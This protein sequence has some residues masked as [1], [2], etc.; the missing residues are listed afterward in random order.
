[1]NKRIIKVGTRASELALTQTI[2]VVNEMKKHR[3]DFEFETVKITTQGDKFL[4]APLSQIGGKGLFVKEIENALLSGDIHMAVHSMKDIPYEI[5]EKL[6]VMA[7]LKREDPRD[8]F[9]SIDGAG[10]MELREGARIGTSSIRREAQL[11]AIRQDIEVVPLRG[12]VRTRLRKMEELNLD[13][14]VLAA[15]GLNRLG[16]DNMITEYF[17]VD[18]IVPAPCQGIL[19]IEISE[20]F[21]EEFMEIYP[22]LLD[23]KTLF[24]ASVERKVMKRFG[25]NC[26]VPFGV[27]AQ[28]IKE[29]GKDK[30]NIK[31]FYKK[32][33]KL[34]R[35]EETGTIDDIDKLVNKLMQKFGGI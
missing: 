8:A 21:E 4:D 19:A 7:V 17:P 25:G 28:Y 30:V 10:F 35:A 22:D 13:G 5:P 1:M 15:A 12:N 3:P 23:I 18:L 6:K 16:L 34:L 24:E 33:E 11:K 29:G 32:G 2:I 26:K 9:I 27:H 14:I 20:S 31:V